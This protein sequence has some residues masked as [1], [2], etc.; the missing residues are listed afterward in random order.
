MSVNL[1]NVEN[2]IFTRIKKNTASYL[3]TKYSSLSVK[4]TM[5]DRELAEPSF[6]TVF[7]KQLTTPSVGNTFDGGI[8]AGNFTFQIE[9]YDNVS[10]T[11]SKDVLNAVTK[12]MSDMFFNVTSL[13]VHDNTSSVYRTIA[14]FNRV[15]GVDD[16]L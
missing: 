2:L 16:T 10:Q 7:I 5:D 3:G 8:N 9:V 12:V 11:R 4:Y 1:L 13:P 15:I 14:R 6:P